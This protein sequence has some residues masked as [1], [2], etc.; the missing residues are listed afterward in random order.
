MQKLPAESTIGDTMP[1]HLRGTRRH[2]LK[3]LWLGLVTALGIGAFVRLPS[4]EAA[5]KDATTSGQGQG[6]E[7]SWVLRAIA[8][9]PGFEPAEF[10][11]LATMNSDGSAVGSSPFPSL[12]TAHGAWVRTGNGEFAATVVYLRADQN[13]HFIGISKVHVRLTLNATKDRASGA[14]IQESFDVDGNLVR[15]IE[16]P[17]E[18]TRIVVEPFSA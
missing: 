14:F 18:A 5:P 3:R 16:A 9:V 15:V 13:E 4:A 10:I 17:A 12:S 7:G 11:N 8:T 2:V 6:L 1:E